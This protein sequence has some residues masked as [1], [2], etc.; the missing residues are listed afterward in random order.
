[1]FFFIWSPDSGGRIPDDA[2]PSFKRGPA[3]KA[4]ARRRLYVQAL[5]VNLPVAFR[6]QTVGSGRNLP[7]RRIDIA[8]F[9][10]FI[11]EYGKI[12]IGQHVGKRG[13]VRIRH[14]LN[15][16][17][18]H[19]IGRLMQMVTDALNQ[20]AALRAQLALYLVGVEFET[21]IH[22]IFPQRVS[23]GR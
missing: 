20:H 21:G 23:I 7:Q 18:R 6:A 1:M 17:K 9:G 22:D 12:H 15:Q 16:G 8:Q 3:I 14:G 2:T 10:Y 19:R 5:M 13:I 11:S 4:L